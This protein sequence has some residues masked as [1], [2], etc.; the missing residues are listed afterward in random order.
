MN[1]EQWFA[2]ANA[3]AA[4]AGDAGPTEAE[5]IAHQYRRGG[6][7]SPAGNASSY[8]AIESGQAAGFGSRAGAQDASGMRAYARQHGMSED[9][10]RFDDA[11]LMSWENEKMDGCPPTHP[12]KSRVDGG[13]A[14]KP[15]DSSGSGAGGGGGG[16]GGRGG[17]GGGRGGGGGGRGGGRGTPIYGHLE[18]TSLAAANDPNEALGL[19]GMSGGIAEYQA[20]LDQAMARIE[21]MQ[22]GPAKD[23]A[24]ARLREQ[25]AT[26]GMALG[27]AA[28]GIARGDLKGL[29][30]LEEGKRQA[31]LQ[32]QQFYSG[33]GEQRRQFNRGLSSQESMFGQQL[34]WDQSRF[35]QQLGWDQDRFGQELDYNR[36]AQQGNW[37]HAL[38]AAKYQ[39]GEQKKKGWGGLIGGALG[40]VRGSV[41]P[42]IG[43][44][45]GAGA[46]SA[47]G[48]MFSDIRVKENIEPAT[49]G[50]AA[51]KNIPTF[52]FNYKEEV[53]DDPRAG[54]GRKLGVMAQDVEKVLPSAVKETP[55]GIKMIEPMGL[56]AMTM[57]SVK[58]L[59]EKFDKLAKKKRRAK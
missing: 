15:I 55:E 39:S 54:R 24:L 48:G 31:N 46:G 52:T 32:N 7:G 56:L 42:G 34:G 45:V 10:E 27:Q 23:A 53:A 50:L 51:M 4:A 43:T 14:E 20:E 11:T 38:D 37:D 33:L 36:W 17:G 6:L 28:Q 57:N 26:G 21:Q 8:D 22:P 35:G 40:G 5:W 1:R 30:D 44:M 9:F 49:P 3:N 18:S 12:Y 59:D 41:V 2:K 13:C 25:Q 58:E 29:V 16:G 47:I 19:L